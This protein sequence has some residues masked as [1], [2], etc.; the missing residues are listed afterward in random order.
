MVEARLDANVCTCLR[1]QVHE[2][3]KEALHCLYNI[4]DALRKNGQKDKIIELT[5]SFEI[6]A[7][8][9]GIMAN[10]KVHDSGM[11]FIALRSYE[12][13]F[14]TDPEFLIS[15]KSSDAIETLLN[16]QYDTSRN[17]WE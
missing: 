1:D 14:N 9:H 11:T 15:F 10:T 2:V 6:E 3:R 12:I 16:M 4:L 5:L 8:L 7:I 13:L 17:I